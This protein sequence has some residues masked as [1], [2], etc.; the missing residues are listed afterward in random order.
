[1]SNVLADN[2]KAPVNYLPSQDDDEIDL[3][4]L[5]ATLVDS[6]WLIAFITVVVLAIGTAK[7]FL[8]QP[9]YKTDAMLQV[10]ENSPS[11]GALE[12]VAALMEGKVPVEAE[13]ELI[14]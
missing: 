5:L 6:K 3:G 2:K 8:D 12:A 13:I 9:V 11:L 10:E 4:E 7:A 1:M 14:K